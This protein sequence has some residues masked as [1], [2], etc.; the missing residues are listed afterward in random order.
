MK[1]TTPTE[2]A[3]RREIVKKLH[4]TMSHRELA[5][6]LSASRHAITSDCRALVIEMEVLSVAAVYKRASMLA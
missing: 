2:L 1:K 3:R 6:R 5:I 4:G